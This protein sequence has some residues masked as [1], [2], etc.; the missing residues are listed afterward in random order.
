MEYKKENFTV[1]IKIVSLNS[2][3]DLMISVNPNDYKTLAE[4]FIRAEKEI[5]E[6]KKEIEDEPSVKP[7]EGNN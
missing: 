5:S 1:S 2:M 3:L 7:V 4:L 6:L